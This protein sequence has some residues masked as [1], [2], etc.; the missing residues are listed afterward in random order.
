M[1]LDQQLAACFDVMEMFC[2][3]ATVVLAAEAARPGVQ[4]MPVCLLLLHEPTD[5]TM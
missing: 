4:G 5:M 2:D 3:E 1:Q